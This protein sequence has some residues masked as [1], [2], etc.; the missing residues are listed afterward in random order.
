MPVTPVV[1]IPLVWGCI[2][3]EQVVHDL[4]VTVG[5]SLELSEHCARA[6]A[7]DER[8]CHVPSND[9]RGAGR[10]F[11]LRWAWHRNDGGMAAWFWMIAF[12]GYVTKWDAQMG[13]QYAVINP[14]MLV[15]TIGAFE[16][17]IK[18]NRA[19]RFVFGLRA[20]VSS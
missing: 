8:V 1:R 12:L 14:C 3:T 13:M 20:R 11:H 7:R 4:L 6:R 2:V 18:R 5:R 9:N 17:V 10:I 15:G 16:L 19:T